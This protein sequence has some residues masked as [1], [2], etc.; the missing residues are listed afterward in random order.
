MQNNID[1]LV[2]EGK[3]GTT[4]PLKSDFYGDTVWAKQEQ[5]GII[6]E[7]LKSN[8][9]KFIANNI[10]GYLQQTLNRLLKDC[11]LDIKKYV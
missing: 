8:V 11:I 5:I 7:S 3:N 1:L 10:F 6:F 2:F 9:A 4:V